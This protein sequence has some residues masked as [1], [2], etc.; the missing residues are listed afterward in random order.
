ML[1]RHLESLLVRRLRRCLPCQQLVA[2]VARARN[3]WCVAACVRATRE[4][5]PQ[6][7]GFTQDE[8]TTAMPLDLEAEDSD[9][10]EERLSLHLTDDFH[11]AEREGFSVVPSEEAVMVQ[12][13]DSTFDN[14]DLTNWET[15]PETGIVNDFDL[16][17]MVSTHESIVLDDDLNVEEVESFTQGSV[18]L[19][20]RKDDVEMKDPE[21]AVAKDPVEVKVEKEEE[22]QKICLVYVQVLSLPRQR[23]RQFQWLPPQVVLF[24]CCLCTW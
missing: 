8:L 16:V 24:F 19:T 12:A 21:E 23:F 15:V 10:E 2:C 18:T 14:I 7:V 13:G 5:A 17:S 3:S 4:G 11:A 20:A 9:L 1:L 6:G 22:T